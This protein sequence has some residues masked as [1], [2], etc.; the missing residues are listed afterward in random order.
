MPAQRRAFA[1]EPLQQVGVRGRDRPIGVSERF[2]EVSRRFVVSPDGAC[3][4]GCSRCVL[5]DRGDI[6]RTD[7]MQRQASMVDQLVASLHEVRQHPGV[8]LAPFGDAQGVEERPPSDLVTEADHSVIGDHQQAAADALIEPRLVVGGCD[9]RCEQAR[10]DP[11]GHDRRSIEHTPSV[12]GQPRRT[13]EHGIAHRLRHLGSAGAEHLGDEERIPAREVM[14]LVGIE[15]AA[16]GEFADGIEGQRTQ[17]HSATDRRAEIAQA[18]AQRVLGTDLVVAKGEDD[19]C[20]EVRHSSSEERHQVECG[21]IGPVDILDH[22]HHRPLRGTGIE[23]S[24]CSGKRLGTRRAAREPERQITIGNPNGIDQRPERPRRRHR[25]AGTA[26]HH[27]RP[28]GLM[29][30][31]VHDRRLAHPCL[32]RHE[33]QLTPTRPCTAERSMQLGQRV[34]VFDEGSRSNHRLSRRS[35]TCRRRPSRRARGR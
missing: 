8:Q 17:P 29:E 21:L 18:Y 19:H 1:T 26:P 23:Q 12:P 35:R 3:V 34:V 24:E 11:T 25:I 5:D 14:E 28:G 13:S 30:E 6:V 27:R 33:D 10:F 31:R 32:T 20:P 2:L 9:D 22:H 4:S 16:L 15:R 7:G